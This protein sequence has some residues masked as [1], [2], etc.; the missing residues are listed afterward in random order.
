MNRE[1]MVSHWKGVEFMQ[2]MFRGEFACDLPPYSAG[3]RRGEG[4]A[5]GGRLDRRGRRRH[6][7]ERRHEVQRAPLHLHRLEPG[8]RAGRPRRSTQGR[9]HRGAHRELRA[10]GA[11]RHLGRGLARPSRRVRHHVVGLRARARSPGQGRG[12]LRLVAHP[13]RG[14]PGRVQL[15]AGQRSRDRRVAAHRRL[16]HR[17][18]R[19][20]GGVLQHRHQ[21]LQRH[22]Q[23][24]RGRHRR[25]VLGRRQPGCKG[26]R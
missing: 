4:A 15:H 23:R 8:G 13:E 25:A 20:P 17:H 11:L 21:A 1:E 6:S 16:D 7:R 3:R 19:A 26:G 22:R 12:F 5:G 24:D 10:D 14:E 18:R 2:S 9:R